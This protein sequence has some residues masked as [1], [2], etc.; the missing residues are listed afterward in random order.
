MPLI[1]LNLKPPKGLSFHHDLISNQ[2][3][4]SMN[5][6]PISD[7]DLLLVPRSGSPIVSHQAVLASLS[8]LLAQLFKQYSCASQPIVLVHLDL[9]LTTVKNILDIV[10]TGSVVLDTKDKVDQVN[11]GL[12]MLDID[13][14]IEQAQTNQPISPLAT[15]LPLKVGVSRKRSLLEQQ[16]VQRSAKRA[17][18]PTSNNTSAVD[19][20]D[21][22]VCPY[23]TT[24]AWVW[25]I[26]TRQ[27]PSLLSMGSSPS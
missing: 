14:S 25:R 4:K 3:A 24:N 23:C 26:P 9:D 10:Y 13:I 27:S 7:T 12:T 19:Y 16:S 11:N 20:Q 22:G 15:P 6:P 8:P 18:G 1:T 21:N 2:A 17:R 5:K